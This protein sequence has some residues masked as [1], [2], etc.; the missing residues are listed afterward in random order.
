[1]SATTESSIELRRPADLVAAI[2]HLLGFHPEDSLVLIAHRGLPGRAA[3][4]GVVGFTTRVDIPAPEHVPS[5][6]AHLVTVI[7]KQR[8]SAVTAVVIT[9]AEVGHREKLPAAALVD[10]LCAEFAEVGVRVAHALWAPATRKDAAWRC[11]QDPAC[12]GTVADPGCSVA[13][14]TCAVT[15]AVTY[16]GRDELAATLDGDDRTVLARRAALL[17][18]ASDEVMAGTCVSTAEGLA[19]VRTAVAACADGRDELDDEE[20][21]RLVTALA[22]H[23]VRDAML[24]QEDRATDDAAQRL[25][26]ALTRA[27]PEPERAEPACLLACSAYLRGEGA[28]AAVALEKAAAA[29]PGHTLTSLLRTAQQAAVPPWTLRDCLREAVVRARALVTADGE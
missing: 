27:T 19:A 4:D 15:G 12:S 9:E 21:V 11:Y 3:S 18:R 5:L 6:V 23:R 10:E 25:W 17:A 1:M 20:V 16:G 24:L 29:D 13:A 7:G 28:L 26:L 22:D 2:P 14:A 8:P